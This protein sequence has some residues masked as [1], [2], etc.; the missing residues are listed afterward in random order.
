MLAPTPRAPLG[1]CSHLAFRLTRSG[2]SRRDW[3]GDPPTRHA[4]YPRIPRLSL[5]ARRCPC[6][7]KGRSS[8][9]AV[10]TA[11]YDCSTPTAA[12][13]SRLPQWRH[14]S[15]EAQRVGSPGWRYKLARAAATGSWDSAQVR[16]AK[17]S[18][19]DGRRATKAG[20]CPIAHHE[21]DAG[22]GVGCVPRG[23]NS[24]STQ[25][26]RALHRSSSSVASYPRPMNGMF[27]AI[28]VRNCALA[29]R[30]ARPCR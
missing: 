12:V 6:D 14:C 22:S 15:S 25:H 21:T 7:S 26:A 5:L 2:S 4:R 23:R 9:K 29:S 19:R 20:P 13:S 11:G 27:V 3:P 30:V 16:C 1:A 10:T 8:T 28:T 17:R 24:R 18:Q